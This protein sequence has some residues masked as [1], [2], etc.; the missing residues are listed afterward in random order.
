METRVW[1][2]NGRNILVGWLIDL[3]SPPHPQK[4][5]SAAWPF[6]ADALVPQPQELSLEGAIG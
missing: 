4:F 5:K 1:R 2:Q 6:P 3:Q